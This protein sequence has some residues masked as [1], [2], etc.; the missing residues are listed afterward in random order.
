MKKL[1]YKIVGKGLFDDH[2][3]IKCDC[4]EMNTQTGQTYFWENL[5]NPIIE[6]GVTFY[7]RIIAIAP[8]TATIV[9]V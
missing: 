2:V 4:I 6:N 1:E 8:A 3:F 7:R 9:K 5:E